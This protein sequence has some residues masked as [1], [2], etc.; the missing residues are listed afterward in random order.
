M[1]S[2]NCIDFSRYNLVSSAV[3]EEVTFEVEEA[4]DAK[5][6]TQDTYAP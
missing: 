5:V 4:Y 2:I 6:Y 1:F 3:L